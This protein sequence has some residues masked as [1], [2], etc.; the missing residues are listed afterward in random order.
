LLSLFPPV[1]VLDLKHL[2]PSAKKKIDLFHLTDPKNKG[3]ITPSLLLLSTS[4]KGAASLE[5]E[6]KTSAK[7][8][9]VLHEALLSCFA[10]PVF[11]Y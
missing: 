2:Q 7:G 9:C 5:K 4:R 1:K 10:A 8:W 6:D 3:S 11:F